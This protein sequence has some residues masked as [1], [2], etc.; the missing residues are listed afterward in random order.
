M[1]DMNANVANYFNTLYQSAWT[2]FDRDDNGYEALCLRLLRDPQ[3][4]LHKRV[5]C[6]VSALLIMPDQFAYLRIVD[7]C[8]S[9]R[10][11]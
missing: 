11:S 5:T 2:L 9:F 8:T 1:S 6:C 10:T 4:P 7:D 3:L